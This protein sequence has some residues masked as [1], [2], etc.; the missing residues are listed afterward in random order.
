[1]EPYAVADTGLITLS[2]IID[3]EYILKNFPDASLNRNSPIRIDGNAFSMLAD[4]KSVVE[5]YN[6]RNIILKGNIGDV[7]VFTAEP[8][9]YIAK[10]CIQIYKISPMIG[11][12]DIQP[13]NSTIPQNYPDNKPEPKSFMAMIR[14]KGTEQLEIRFSVYTLSDNGTYNLHGIFY[15]DLLSL[16]VQ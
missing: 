6:S 10:E 12:L 1:M 8:K 11:R 13:Y 4:I 14:R 3:T 5:G 2:F 7:I 15:C 9:Q 16:E